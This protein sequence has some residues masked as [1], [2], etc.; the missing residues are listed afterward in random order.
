[1]YI[2]VHTIPVR[3][4]QT[5]RSTWA[6]HINL[7]GLDGVMTTITTYLSSRDSRHC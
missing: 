3:V 4:S 7:S 5:R 2:N 1:M 6:W